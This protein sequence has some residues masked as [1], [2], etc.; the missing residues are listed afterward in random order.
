MGLSLPPLS[1]YI[2][3]PWCVRKCPYCDFN[4]HESKGAV[5][6]SAYVHALLTDLDRDLRGLEPRPLESIF[7]GGG[8]PSLFSPEAIDQ[9]LSGVAQRIELAREIEITMEA[10]PGTLEADRF[11]AYRDVG[12]NRLSIGVQS[13]DGDCLKAL[14]RIHDPQQAYRA[15]EH[16][17]QAGYEL[18]NLDL[19]F[20]LPRQT[21]DKATEDI[22]TALALKPGHL[23]YYQL[24][25]EPNTPFY[26]SPPPLPDED[27]LWDIQRQGHRRLEEVGYYQYEISAYARTGRQCR[28]NLNY[29]TFGDY[30]GIGAGAHGKLTNTQG[31]IRRYAKWRQPRDYIT[32]AR[33]GSAVSKV[34]SLTA[35]DLPLEYMMNRLRLRKGLMRQQYEQRTGLSFESVIEQMYEA[36]SQGMMVETQGRFTCT[37]RGRLYLNDLL[38]LFMTK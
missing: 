25:L 1:L 15:V 3:F 24:T 16:A 29:W 17:K 10:N 18:I 35:K 4:S 36:I 22:E 9:L 37:E 28:H 38:G 8:T 33:Y 13:F 5:D 19:M 34:W 12:V 27:Q 26:H 21:V 23:S 31:E 6:E 32:K 11:D 2:H 20:G 30:L 7:M 14:G